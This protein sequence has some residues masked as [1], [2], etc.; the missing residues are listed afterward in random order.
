M[1]ILN[2]IINLLNKKYRTNKNKKKKQNKILRF[3][4]TTYLIFY[5]KIRKKN[6][7]YAN[8]LFF[9]VGIISIIKN[10]KFICKIVGDYHWERFYRYGYTKSSIEEF[11]K[12]IYFF[13][14]YN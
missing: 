13:N 14:K 5:K 7:L 4:I 11:N 6:I 9:E 12:K 8:G 2:Q 10:R 3:F 1:E